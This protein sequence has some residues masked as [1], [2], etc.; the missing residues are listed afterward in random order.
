MK[1]TK[2]GHCCLLI[3]ENNLR[4]LT[5]PGT[6]SSGQND[7]KNI[8]VILITHDHQ[9]HLHVDSLKTVIQ[10]NPS[11]KIFT[12]DGVGKLLEKENIKYRILRNGQNITEK[13]VIIEGFGEKHAVMYV[14]IPQTENTG[15][16]INNKLFYPG[17]AFTNPEKPVEILALPIAG[18][19]M[20]LPEGIDYAIEI[21][22][23]VCFPVHDGI[24]KN[25]GS[26]N[27][28]PSTILEPLGIKFIV[29]EVE[30]EVI[31]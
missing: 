27:R 3:E 17:D 31:F 18:P 30:K 29:L 10:N 22:P 14:S 21:K 25:I 13:S 8:D 23:R 1:I 16:F 5:D 11:A 2:F 26:T 12:N 28:I 19:W 9:D 6:Y 24:L 7:A 4:I 15:Y 20:N